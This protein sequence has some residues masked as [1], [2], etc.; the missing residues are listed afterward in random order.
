MDLSENLAL[1]VNT[2]LIVYMSA[3]IDKESNTSWFPLG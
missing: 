3:E 2:G 1:V